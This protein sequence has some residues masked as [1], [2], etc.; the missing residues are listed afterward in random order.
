MTASAHRLELESLLARC[1]A[2]RWR[3]PVLVQGSHEQCLRWCVDNL[4]VRDVLWVSR[5]APSGG[6]QLPPGKANHELGREADCVVVDLFDG[7]NA[8]TLAA[9]AGMVRAGGCLVLLGPPL[10]EWGDF[11]DP[12][13]DRIRVE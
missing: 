4:P 11:P 3:L 6:W 9:V 12:E 1:G 10:E 5:S 13:Y 7:L 8:D 2:R